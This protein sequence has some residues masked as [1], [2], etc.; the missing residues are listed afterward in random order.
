M[1]ATAIAA[2]SGRV[3]LGLAGAGLVLGGLESVLMRGQLA[4]PEAGVVPATLYHQL[5]TL[6]GVSLV[7]LCVLP[8]AF[9]LFLL[10]APE[11]LGGGGTAFPRLSAF[12]A[13]LWVAAAVLLHAGWM[14][15]GMSGA[16]L[17]GNASMTSIEWSGR[18]SVFEQTRLEFRAG[19]VDWW[20]LGMALVAVAAT[21]MCLEVVGTVLR[22]RAP[23]KRLLDLTPST[24]NTGL[25]ALL[26]LVAFP[27]LATAMLL[28]LRDRFLD[29]GL[30][31][32]GGGAGDP[33]LWPRLTAL[34]GHP[35]VAMLLLPAMGLAGEIVAGTAGRPL[36]GRAVMRTGSAV[37][38]FA[39]LLSWGA[40]AL[41]AGAEHAAV[42]MP[43]A[44]SLMA[45]VAGVAVMHWLATLWGRPL[46]WG[47]GIGF[48]CAMAAMLTTGAWSALPLALQ[49]V[50]VRQSG[51]YYTV[52]H[53]HEMLF[54]GVLLGLV[55][56][57]Y[58]WGPRLLG[59]ALDR[60][61]GLLHLAL[62]LIGGFL[63]FVP[64]HLL[65]LAGMP[66]RVHT[67]GAGLGWE[68]GNALASVGTLVLLL[69][70]LA[71]AWALRAA[72]PVEGATPGES[73]PGMSMVA[74]GVTLAVTAPIL[75]WGAF[76]AGLALVGAGA[77]RAGRSAKATP[78][79]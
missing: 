38:A 53:A 22:R 30:F 74:A 32:P 45:L 75:G 8:A 77:T 39:G 65:G 23:G 20:A 34:L 54:G 29:A 64:M 6:H 11:R 24:W 26:G 58:Q 12:A 9:G 63:T 33:T 49:P 19:G 69:A 46:T 50:A 4:R 71:F 41:P 27:A 57:L 60:R 7:F 62:T 48:V 67:Y 17:L 47:P 5:L 79:G 66:R 35:Q 76:G 37:L 18:E 21:L 43:V 68:G 36:H 1:N 61:A 44:G 3:L 42:L 31:V 15:G 73:L 70:G 13:R 72:K 55:A 2:R 40:Q 51:T 28:L 52:A 10:L 16:G 25:A 14:L 59:R 78:Q 56:A